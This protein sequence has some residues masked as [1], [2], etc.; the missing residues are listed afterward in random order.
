MTTRLTLTE[1]VES[2]KGRFPKHP[3]SW[4]WLVQEKGL[5]VMY[6]VWLG[7]GDYTNKTRYHGA[8]PHGYLQ[9]LLAFF[10]DIAP[11]H[12][13]HAYAGSVPKG[14]YLRID[15]NPATE[16]DIVGNVYDVA[17][18]VGARRFR[19]ICADPPYTKIDN[20]RY[21]NKGGVDRR[22]ATAALAA[23]TAPHGFLAWLDTT[24]PIYNAKDW[25]IVGRIY[26]DRSTGHRIRRLAI[27]ERVA[28]TRV[29]PQAVNVQAANGCAPT[30]ATA[31]EKPADLSTEPTAAA[32]V[33][34]IGCAVGKHGR[35][36]DSDPIE[37]GAC[38]NVPHVCAGCGR[39][40]SETSWTR[41]AWD[42]HQAKLARKVAS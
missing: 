24:A 40:V 14:D 36:I 42:A 4:P 21:G 19:L 7:G 18:L 41:E 37:Y 2:F 9:K 23:V 10:P 20:L 16:P 31:S 27:F 8:Y 12:T 17:T 32:D 26:I 28:V 25:R 13:L 1:R 30:S 6:A 29:I 3:A 38:V 11:Q 5:P 35:L 34:H 15:L 33:V 39:T 22:R